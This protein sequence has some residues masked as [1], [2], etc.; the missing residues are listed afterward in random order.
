MHNESQ[1]KLLQI[2][3]HRWN[4]IIKENNQSS[5]KTVETK[6]CDG[7]LTKIYEDP[8]KLIG[9]GFGEHTKYLMIDIDKNSPYHPK[10]DPSALPL[11]ELTLYKIG[12]QENIKIQSSHSEGIHIYYPWSQK[13]KSYI[14]GLNITQY[15]E[16]NGWTVKNGV[17]EIFPNKKKGEKTDDKRQWKLYQRHRLPLQPNSGSYLLDNRYQPI[18]TPHALDSF[19]NQ[20]EK[21]SKAQ[22]IEK[23]KKC[24]HVE[25]KINVKSKKSKK[26]LEIEKELNQQIEQGFTGN[27]QTN[28]IL[29][30]LGR[31]IRLNQKLG[32]IELRDTIKHI[33]TNMTGYEEYCRHKYEIH[34]RCQDIARW[35]ET[36][37]PLDKET[38]SKDLPKPT[39]NNKE[40][41]QDALNRIIEAMKI[42]IKKEYKN[43]TAF[44]E[45]ICRIAKCSASTLYKH[46]QIWREKVR[47]KS[48][49]N[50]IQSNHLKAIEEQEKQEEQ[51]DLKAIASKENKQ[52]KETK[53][54]QTKQKENACNA[55]ADE[56]LSLE[57]IEKYILRLY[58]L[59]TALEKKEN[60]NNKQNETS[61]IGENSQNSQNSQ[62]SASENAEKLPNLDFQDF[63]STGVEVSTEVRALD[64]TASELGVEGAVVGVECR[65]SE[66]GVEGAGVGKESVVS[67][68]GAI[69]SQ[70]KTNNRETLREK[71]EAHLKKLQANVEKHRLGRLNVSG[72]KTAETVSSAS[73]T[74]KSDVVKPEDD[75]TIA[76]KSETVKS[77]LAKLTIGELQGIKALPEKSELSDSKAQSEVVNEEGIES[78]TVNLDVATSEVIGS[79]V[80]DKKVVELADQSIKANCPPRGNN[81]ANGDDKLSQEREKFLKSL[82]IEIP[83]TLAELV[84]KATMEQL[85]NVRQLLKENKALNNP[86]GFL[87]KALKNNWQPKPKPSSPSKPSWR[88]EFEAFYHQAIKAGYCEDLPINW[89]STN[90]RHEP[91]VRVTRPD[92]WTSAPYTLLYWREA[93][94]EFWGDGGINTF[95]NS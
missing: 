70:T 16:R 1:Q 4:W 65:V 57:I 40:K 60:K 26:S 18:F 12:L 13:L 92:S 83:E 17:L 73:Q 14:V 90:H 55:L 86:V 66:L 72:L 2:F 75:L 7:T 50:S 15:L 63:S 30:N 87:I 82:G 89:L 9:V 11:L 94:L 19:V 76:T 3:T 62:N 85:N 31:R 51:K 39:T 28:D 59:S 68:S 47:I 6:I 52:K 36:S 5:W 37:N 81:S 24:L 43:I 38:K 25:S 95:N 93:M 44:I 54:K 71:I 56:G 46:Q 84:N 22:D 8:S 80:A 79:G 32:G 69:G 64:S 29:L 61:E 58:I 78:A 10:N 49:C 42:T 33:I 77:G 35:A 27:G 34:Q 45:E 21:I 74:A 67:E 20:W 53:Q 88:E 23:F 41:A 48:V 91:M